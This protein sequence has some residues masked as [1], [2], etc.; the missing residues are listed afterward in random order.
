MRGDADR[1]FLERSERAIRSAIEV[2]CYGGLSGCRLV[3]PEMVARH[4]GHIVNIAS[5]AGLVAVRGQAVYAGAKFVV[6]GLTTALAD[7]FAQHGV[8]VSAVLPTFTKHGADHGHQDLR[9]AEAGAA[10]GHRG[11]RSSRSWTS[12]KPL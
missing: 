8:E 6:V 10:G 1:P 7:E 11:P 9:G 4:S 12:P 3:L 2:S 5:V